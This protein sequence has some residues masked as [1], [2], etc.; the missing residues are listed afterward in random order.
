MSHDTY[1]FVDELKKN[2]RVVNNRANSVAQFV[3][4]G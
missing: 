3:I 1:N 4:N 2:L